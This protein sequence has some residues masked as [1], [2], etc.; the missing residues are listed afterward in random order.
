MQEGMT[1]QVS[2]TVHGRVLTTRKPLIMSHIQQNDIP[3]DLMELVKREGLTSGAVLPLLVGNRAFGTLEVVSKRENSV[4]EQDLELLTQ[5]ADQVAIG[6]ANALA[7][8]EIDD[9]KQK[10]AEEKLYLEDEIRSEYF[11]EIVG[12]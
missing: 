5:L 10:L 4:A 7:Y 8:K 9:L 12:E 3:A 6:V 11:D 1:I 2:G